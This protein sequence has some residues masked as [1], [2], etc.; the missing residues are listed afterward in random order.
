MLLAQINFRKKKQFCV[1]FQRYFSISAFF[2]RH[3]KDIEHLT[4][5]KS[6]DGLQLKSQ[7]I[8]IVL[9]LYTP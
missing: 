2:S 4:Y 1:L 6:V 5:N 3:V 8:I 7:P 9:V